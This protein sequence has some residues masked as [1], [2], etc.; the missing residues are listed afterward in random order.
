MLLKLDASVAIS[1]LPSTGRRNDILPVFILFKAYE[2]QKKLKAQYA[3]LL[4]LCNKE[5]A[6][7]QGKFYDLMYAN[8]DN[9][10]FNSTKK[11]AFLRGDGKS[12]FLVVVNF[13]DC[14]SAV[15]VNIPD[16]AFTFFK[17]ERKKIEKATPMLNGHTS[18]IT[19][20]GTGMFEIEVAAYSG[21]IYRLY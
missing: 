3:T 4:Q 7:S 18:A 8:Y 17:T 9:V 13:N 21:E 12:L 19:F 11:Y 2:H 1:S 15:K 10:A 16:D 20:S 6:I 5:K 14:E